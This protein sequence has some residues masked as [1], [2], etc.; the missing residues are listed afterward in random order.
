MRN[1][2]PTAYWGRSHPLM[3]RCPTRYDLFIH[4]LLSYLLHQAWSRRRKHNPRDLQML[5]FFSLVQKYVGVCA[6]SSLFG[7][8]SSACQQQQVFCGPAGWRISPCQANSEY[9]FHDACEAA[10]RYKWPLGNRV[11]S[12]SYL[13]SIAHNTYT[14]DFLNAELWPVFGQTLSRALRFI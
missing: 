5:T 8:S 4:H 11:H 9:G 12:Q 14:Q 10:R 7:W 3:H 13:A 6:L 1:V 2:D